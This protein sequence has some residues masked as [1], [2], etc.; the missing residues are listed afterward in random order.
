[1]TKLSTAEGTD[2]TCDDPEYVLEHYRAL[3]ERFTSQGD[4][5]WKRFHFFLTVDVALVGAFLLRSDIAKAGGLDVWG[6]RLGIV[7]SVVWIIIAVQDLWFYDDARVRLNTFKKELILPKIS[8]WQKEREKHHP[9]WWKL[10]VCFRIARIG[11]TAFAPIC[12][13]LFLAVWFWLANSR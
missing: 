10:P 7:V 4:R 8:S 9:P 5:L 12:A 2:H 11:V 3:R 13:Y 6:P 1:M